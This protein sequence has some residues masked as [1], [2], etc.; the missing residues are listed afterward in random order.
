VENTD[1]HA[2]PKNWEDLH[3]VVF[4]K[5][6]EGDF[7]TVVSKIGCFVYTSIRKLYQ[8]SLCAARGVTQFFRVVQKSN[9]LRS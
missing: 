4:A 2:M 5:K 8:Q 1:G 6:G 3:G 9:E 7:M